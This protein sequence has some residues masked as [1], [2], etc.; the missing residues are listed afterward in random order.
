MIDITRPKNLFL[1]DGIGAIASI[2]MLGEVLVV[3]Q[4]YVGIPKSTLYL[5]AAIPVFF[6]L[7]DIYSYVAKPV[8]DKRNLKIIASLNS[9][10]CCLSL[11]MAVYHKDV[12]TLLGWL[13]IIAEIL[14][15]AYIVFIELKTAK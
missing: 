15:I 2:I 3:L 4:P 14:I 5:L 7:F 9:M 13:Y 6:L 1:L 10:Y 11:I 12:V 8:Y